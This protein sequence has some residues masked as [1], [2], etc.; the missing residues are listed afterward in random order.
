MTGRKRSR[1]LPILTITNTL[2][3]LLLYLAETLV[4]ERHWITAVIT[5]SPQHL[6]GIPCVVLI[7]WSVLRRQW[8]MAAINVV[9]AGAFTV[10]LLG[11]NVPFAAAGSGSGTP[12]RVMTFNIHH[13]TEGLQN[14]VDLIERE[15]PDLICLQEANTWQDW[16]DPI[17]EL[18]RLLPDYQVARASQLAVLSRYPI[19][20]KKVHQ[21]PN[22]EGRGMLEAQVVLDGKL[23]TVFCVHMESFGSPRRLAKNRKSARVR[24]N[25]SISV[26]S[27]LVSQLIQVAGKSREAPILAAG[28]FNTPPRGK[29]YGKL[30]GRF[31]DAFRASGWGFGKTFRSD[32][33]VLRIDHILLD[34]DIDVRRCWVPVRHASDHRPVVADLVLK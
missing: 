13:A 30:T 11:F 14:I 17:P 16:P 32:R 1:M 5:Y 12:F 6:L 27:Q 24:I 33:P 4:A 3:L 26:R 23:L 15:Q 7:L 31:K 20:R 19:V 28:D 29:V 22:V 9:T 34:D 8:R 25:R 2:L 21:L 10:T 18:R